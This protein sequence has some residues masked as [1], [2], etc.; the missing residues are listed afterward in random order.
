MTNTTPTSLSVEVGGKTITFE[1]GL[2]AKQSDG[3][4]VA[5]LGDTMVLAAAVSDKNQK[6]GLQDFVPLTVNYKERTYAAGKIPGGFFKRESRPSK[7]ETLSSRLIDRSMRPLFPEGFACEV[8]ITAMVISADGVNDSDVL[9]IAASSAATVISS[10]PFTTPVAGVRVN[11]IN[12]QYVINPTIEERKTAD[13]DLVIAGT[14]DGIMMV[15]GGAHEVEEEALVKAIEIA[16]PEIK[17]LCQAQFDLREKAG[18]PKFEFAAETLPQDVL[19]ISNNKYRAEVKNILHGFY[20]KQ[21]RD[22]KIAQLKEAFKNELTEAYPEQAQA[23]ADFAMEMLAYEESRAMVLN[24]GVRVD[25]RK[26]E[27]IRP[28]SSMVGLLPGAHG[29]A[30]FTRGQT[31]SLAVATLGTAD[32]AQMVEGLEETYDEKFMLHYNFPGFATGECKPDR[33]PGRREIGHGELAR[34]ALLPLLPSEAEFPYTIRVVSDIMESNGSSSMASVCGGSLAL[35]DAG[36]PMKGTCSGIAMGLITQGDKYAVLSDI[37]GL[38]DHLGDM[39]FKL[40]GSRKGITAFQMDLKLASGISLDVLRKA[41]AQAT[42]GRL[43]IMDHM[44]STLK[45]PRPNISKKAPVIYTMTIPQDKIGALIGPGGKNIKR[46]T[47]ATETKI[48]IND[49]G[50]VMIAA[51]NDDKLQA[52][53]AEIELLTKDVEVNQIYKGK[54]VSIQPFGAFVELLP[55]KDGLLHISEIDKKRINKVEDVLALGDIVEVKVVEI[56]NN[57][58][59]RLSRK[60]LLK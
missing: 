54:V 17:K 3:S 51:A 21:T 47:E 34:R 37:M 43:F 24:E 16:Q 39:D 19:D 12:G 20:D 56:D 27:E 4:V 53:K 22:T 29:S 14:L 55:G 28:L 5:R 31:Q 52:A 41:I 23:Y 58:K 25:G 50:K 7:K 38:E 44:E 33:S 8:N 6:P 32:D 2:I 11:R 13:M 18:K 36:V 30:L 1:T 57:G 40:T 26:T 45:E 9:S 35:F 15:E 48:D 42:R 10:I 46:I 49:D 60:A 59:V